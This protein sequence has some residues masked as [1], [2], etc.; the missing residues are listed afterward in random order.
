LDVDGGELLVGDFDSFGV[1]IGVEAGVDL[2]AGAGGGRG[3]EVDDDLVGEEWF[4]APVLADKAEKPVL[5]FVPLAGGGRE[6]ADADGEAGVVCEL[7]QLGLPEL[8]AVAV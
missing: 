2:E 4:A 7:L 1:G 5:D 3:D 6:V 8:G